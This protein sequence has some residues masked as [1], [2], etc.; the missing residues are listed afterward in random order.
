MDG[1]RAFRCADGVAAASNAKCA[2]VRKLKMAWGTYWGQARSLF[3]PRLRTPA[4]H[5]D[6]CTNTGLAYWVF[7][8]C[9]RIGRVARHWLQK[10][11][12]FVRGGHGP[13]VSRLLHPFIRCTEMPHAGAQRKLSAQHRL[14]AVVV[15]ACADAIHGTYF[16][17]GPHSGVAMPGPFRRAPCVGLACSSAQARSFAP[18]PKSR[19]ASASHG[20]F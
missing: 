14:Q 1:Q 13:G 18:T 10:G 6:I 20:N 12:R 7:T 16:A 15:I 11:S 17:Q 9:S 8:Y 2:H 3:L 4:V 5:S 19:V